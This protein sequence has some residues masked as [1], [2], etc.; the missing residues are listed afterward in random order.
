MNCCRTCRGAIYFGRI[1]DS[2]ILFFRITKRKEIVSSTH[3][4]WKHLPIWCHRWTQG[5]SCQSELLQGRVQLVQHQQQPQDDEGPLDGCLWGQL[6]RLGEQEQLGLQEQLGRQLGRQLMDRGQSRWRG[7]H[8][9]HMTK[10]CWEIS[11]RE[12]SPDKGCSGKLF[13]AIFW[14]VESKISTLQLTH[15]IILLKL[16]LGYHKLEV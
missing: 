8:M 15:L 2:E 11:W 10:G 12:P 13:Q 14:R 7:W 5:H 9:P 3:F 16:L 4:C 1:K 6:G